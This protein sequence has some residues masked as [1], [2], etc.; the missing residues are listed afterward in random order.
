MNVIGTQLRDMTK[1]ARDPLAI[2]RGYGWTSS[3]KAGEEGVESV[4]ATTFFTLGAEGKK[5]R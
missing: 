4:K 3:R 1:L 5:A 2:D